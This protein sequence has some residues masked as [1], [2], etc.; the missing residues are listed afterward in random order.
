V[1]SVIAIVVIAAAG[2]AAALDGGSD[3]DSDRPNVR[4]SQL[5]G[6]DLESRVIPTA[7][8]SAI[9]SEAFIRGQA[10][11]GTARAVFVKGTARVA[12]VDRS[13]RVGLQRA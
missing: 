12:D 5:R 4:A 3:S 9:D 2:D 13:S 6:V 1:K 8:R 7:E 10:S 11:A